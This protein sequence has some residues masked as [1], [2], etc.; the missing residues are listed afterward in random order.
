MPKIMNAERNA[1]EVLRDWDNAGWV[2][3][4]DIHRM[5]IDLAAALR[6]TL[7]ERRDEITTIRLEAEAGARNMAAVI[8]QRDALAAQLETSSPSATPPPRPSSPFQDA[9]FNRAIELGK[10][11]EAKLA[12]AVE[13]LK[14]YAD[15]V[16]WEVDDAD[17]YWPDAKL[18]AVDDQGQ[19][20]R[21]ALREIGEPPA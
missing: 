12:R 2:T 18:P 8:A 5:A 16:S 10:K 11:A 20:A 6:A 1:Q 13:A 3:Y 4:T 17:G 19:R 21:E 7:A 15:P 14:F 9:L